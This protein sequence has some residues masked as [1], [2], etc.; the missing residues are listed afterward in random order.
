MSVREVK[1]RLD[2]W[3]HK[4]TL[5]NKGTKMEAMQ[6][7]MKKNAEIEFTKIV[8][9]ENDIKE[10]LGEESLPTIF[11]VPYLDFGRQVYR[12]K[13]LYTDQALANEITII[14]D[15]WRARGLQDKIMEKIQAVVCK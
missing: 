10:I 9:L 13:K 4:I 7:K 6:P 3:E 5:A 1:R 2:K 12:L 14:K 11:N 8:K 15:K